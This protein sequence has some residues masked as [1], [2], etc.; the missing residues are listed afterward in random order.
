M[1]VTVTSPMNVLVMYLQ[2]LGHLPDCELSYECDRDLSYEGV[3]DALA[4]S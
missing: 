3:G 1:T 2:S 4:V